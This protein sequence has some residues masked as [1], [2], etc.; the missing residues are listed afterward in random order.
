MTKPINFKTMKLGQTGFSMIELLVVMFIF[1][2]LLAIAAPS[3]IGQRP[4]QDLKRLSREIVS[5][6]QFA[7]VSAIKRSATWAIQF[8]PATSEY[9]VL[10]DD[11][12]DGSWGTSDDTVFKTVSLSNYP[13]ITFAIPGGYGTV[14]TETNPG[15][16]V[17]FANNRVLFNS[18]GTSL[19]GTVYI[20]NSRNDAFAIRIKTVAGG[21]KTWRNFNSGWQG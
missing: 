3:F 21:I 18:N 1:A 14:D 5:D 11:G 10:S 4:R 20:S 7:K 12:V 13:G 17:S 16:G 2:V 19:I 9:K 6:M 15:D 8:Y